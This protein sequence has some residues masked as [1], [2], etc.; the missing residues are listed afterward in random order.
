MECEMCGNPISGRPTRI[1]I[2]GTVMSTCKK[3]A[4]FGVEDGEKTGTRRTPAFGLQR[5]KRAPPKKEIGNLEL[6][7]DYGARIRRARE[8]RSL[9][10]EELGNHI[11]ER[12]SVIARMESQKMGIS[13]KMARKLERLLEIKL[14]E[15]LE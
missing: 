6:V 8:Q 14:F 3:C 11:N 13:E 12:A 15:E 7:E 1:K 5:P 4:R 2:E 10:Q 9:T